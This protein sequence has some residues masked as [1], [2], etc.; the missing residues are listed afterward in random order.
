MRNGGLILRSDAIPET[1]F[2][3][4][5]ESN[6]SVQIASGKGILYRASDNHILANVRYQIWERSS[7]EKQRG[8]WWGNIWIAEEHDD[9]AAMLLGGES[10]FRL[11]LEDGRTGQSTLTLH[12]TAGQ[13]T[14]SLQGT[15]PLSRLEPR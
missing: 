4:S 13:K 5:L 6:M 10:K 3:T 2:D 15:E 7:T 11:D 1:F 12:V 8:A 14:Y 9:L